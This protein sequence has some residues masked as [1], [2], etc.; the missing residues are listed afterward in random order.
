MSRS[1]TPT[2]YMTTWCPYCRALISD[3]DR[4]GIAYAPVDVDRDAAAG[5]FVKSVNNGNRVV[6]TVLFADG[7]TL[8]NPDVSQVAEKLA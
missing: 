8:T 4:A 6:P 3:L 2:V 7:S 1:T 5:E